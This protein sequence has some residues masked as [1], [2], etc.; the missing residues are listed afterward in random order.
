[1]YF[2][3]SP[4][5][6]SAWNYKLIATTTSGCKLHCG[7]LHHKSAQGSACALASSL[8]PPKQSASL[9][10]A[11][12]QAH[13]LHMVRTYTLHV[14]PAEA[15]RTLQQMIHFH[16]EV[17]P[18]GRHIHRLALHATIT[19]QDDKTA[20]LL[21]HIIRDTPVVPIDL[22]IIAENVL[23]RLCVRHKPAFATEWHEVHTDLDAGAPWEDL[24]R[25]LD[26]VSVVIKGGKV[27]PVKRMFILRIAPD[28]TKAATF[29]C[30]LDSSL[31]HTLS[32]APVAPARK[33]LCFPMLPAP[34]CREDEAFGVCITC[35]SQEESV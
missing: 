18:Q 11:A 14:G 1:M 12:S 5:Q 10:S 19:I 7:T 29:K 34:E 28:C 13:N 27:Q 23:G 21:P 24:L 25:A 35:I 30:R 9:R 4:V 8:L 20:T 31:S 26:K 15:I 16:R 32:S 22:Q 6:G 2:L 17:C 3:L 33:G